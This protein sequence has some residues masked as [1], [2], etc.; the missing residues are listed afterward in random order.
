MVLAKENDRKQNRTLAIGSRITT[1]VGI[2][3]SGWS[4]NKE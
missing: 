3:Q 1:A 4:P 2:K